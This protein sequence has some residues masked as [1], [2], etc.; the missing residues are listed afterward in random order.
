MRVPAILLLLLITL[1]MAMAGEKDTDFSEPVDD[2]EAENKEFDR[3]Q[4]DAA[5]FLL[6]REHYVAN[7]A[8]DNG[9]LYHIQ[10]AHFLIDH[11]EY[12]W[13]LW[14]AT[15]TVER[16]FHRYPFSRYAGDLLELQMDCYIARGR[17][18]DANDTLI[19]LWLFMPDY[20]RMGEAMLKAL[21]AAEHAQA[22][23][24]AVNLEASDPG[25]VI[26]ITGNGTDTPTDKL[27][28]FLALHGDRESIAPRAELGQ[29]RAQLLGGS[30]E[31]RFA[32]QHSYEKFLEDYPDNDLTFTALTEEALAHL[33]GYRG[34]DYDNGALVFASAIIDQA[35]LETRGDEEKARTVEAYRRRI[36]AW[37]QDRDLK[38]ARWYHDRNIPTLAWLMTP[39]GL[40]S[41]A[42]GSRYYYQA[43]VARDSGSSQGRAA[44]REVRTVPPPV[45]R[46]PPPLNPGLAP[47]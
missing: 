4:R 25:D 35:E 7:D 17:L 39:P 19:Q 27:F 6:K 30:R 26:A 24:K 43:V 38:I 45:N 28:R 10:H 3:I 21:E 20:P 8:D 16:G 29:A 40:V 15:W 13:H 5:K 47:K 37:M 18:A 31:D 14:R 44:A 46:D 34:D 33:V 22:F 2:T 32:A 36:R 41:W 9:A 11:P 23:A 1:G 12:W 42:D